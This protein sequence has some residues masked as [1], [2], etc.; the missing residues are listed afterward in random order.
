[1]IAWSVTALKVLPNHRLEVSFADG[2]TV[3]FDMS[4]DSFNGVFAP[5]ADESYFAQAT[6][7]AGVVVWPNGLDIAPDAMYDDIMTRAIAK[8][9][10]PTRARPKY[11][12]GE[13]VAQC[14]RSAPVPADMAAWGE[15]KP[16]GREA[17]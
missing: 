11:S 17:R 14:D 9:N 2:L 1:M 16:V 8:T 15:M 5:L 7:R 3:V 12:L 10:A 6:I 13:L 4:N